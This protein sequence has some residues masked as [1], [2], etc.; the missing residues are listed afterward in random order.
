M[1]G[2]VSTPPEGAPEFRGC[3]AAGSGRLRRRLPVELVERSD[4][5]TLVALADPPVEAALSPSVEELDVAHEQQS[6]TR[7]TLGGRWWI[8]SVRRD[9][10][11]SVGLG[12][13]ER[14][15]QARTP[16]EE[17]HG[18]SMSKCG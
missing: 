4:R 1:L 10:D 7:K 16:G 17:R 2:R 5:S 14:G 11:E 18:A 9:G 15:G 3:S 13:G 6:P 8:A 12:C